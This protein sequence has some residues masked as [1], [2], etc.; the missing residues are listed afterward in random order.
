[1][2]EPQPRP[3]VLVAGEALIDIV[4]PV[5]GPDSEH[6]GGSPA[7]V[8]VGLSRLDHPTRLAT[9]I[10][11]D[12]RGERITAYLSQRGVRLT[13]GSDHADHTPTAEASVDAAGVATYE[14]DLQW[15][16]PQ[17]DLSDIGHVH[18]GSIAAT[19]DPGGRQV[20][21]LIEA[22]RAGA[23][24][25]YDPNARPSI[26]GSPRDVRQRIEDCIGRSD[27]VKCSTEDIDWLYD[28]AP[29]EEVARE[30]GRLG[31]GLIIVTQGGE[32]AM[33]HLSE[34]GET[35]TVP[36]RRV[37]VKDTV[38]AGDSFMAGLIS[39]LLDEELLGSPEARTRLAST[40]MTA[41]Q[42][43]VARGV[44]TSAYTVARVGAASPTRADLDPAAPG[45][46]T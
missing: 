28:G 43:A 22:A 40:E 23:T 10:G 44:A 26:M 13:E 5:D 8:A 17:V 36:A 3:V 1:M 35:A 29:V 19:L 6:V 14:F 27:V 24:V 12:E 18:T 33:V 30:W 37:D 20:V 34:S 2:S 25:S 21:D 45:S 4:R 9:H 16:L 46:S 41:V 42:R 11:R 32:G 39:G 7:N 38:G 31:P 15:Q